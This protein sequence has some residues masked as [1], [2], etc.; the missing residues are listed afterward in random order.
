MAGMISTRRQRGVS[1]GF[2]PES[3]R[4][5][6]AHRN[7]TN[8]TIITPTRSPRFGAQPVEANVGAVRI[9]ATNCR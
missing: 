9:S 4:R 7:P 6:A 2:T 3:V 8:W 5:E 1:D